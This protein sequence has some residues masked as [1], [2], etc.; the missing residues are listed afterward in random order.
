MINMDMSVLVDNT[1][2]IASQ[3]GLFSYSENNLKQIYNQDFVFNITLNN[4]T[5]YFG[6]RNGLNYL[7]DGKVTS[8]VNRK[9]ISRWLFGGK[10]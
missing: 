5:I 8:L 9:K 1:L 4:G 10:K 7:K 2:W 3:S 6:T